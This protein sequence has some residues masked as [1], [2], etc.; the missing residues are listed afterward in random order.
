MTKIIYMGTPEFAVP[1]LKSMAAEGYNIP[2]VVTQPD[3]AKDRGKKIQAP[4]VKIAA[5]CLGIPVIQPETIKGNEDFISFIKKEAPDLIVVVAYGK[6]LP[7]ELLAIPPMGCINIHGSLLPKFRGAAPIQRAI[8]E[9]EIRTGITLMYMEEGLDTG[10]MIAFRE[11]D[12]DNKNAGQLHDELSVMGAELLIE[13]L[14]GILSG[15]ALRC[16]QDDKKASYAPMIFKQ[17]GLVDFERS[18][19]E[20]ERQVRG[21]NPWPSA[22]TFYKSEQ[23]KII[24]A[25]ALPEEANAMPGSIIE[26][27]NDGIKVSTGKGNLLIT[28][29]QMPGKKPLDVAEYI[30]GNKIEIS[31]YLG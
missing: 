26:V 25:R 13:T 30:K 11:T 18:S 12:I 15:N 2:W 1:P 28:R 22:F 7:P 4:P 10:D 14:P 6:I 5:E 24:E 8:I 21:L 16:K 29:I 23:M 3:K 17:D 19:I 27:S 31:S 9:G 20:I